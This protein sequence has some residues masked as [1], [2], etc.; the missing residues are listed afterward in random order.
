M[1]S[2]KVAMV[3]AILLM[4][5]VVA[6]QAQEGKV[7]GNCMSECYFQCMQIRIFTWSECRSKCVKACTKPSRGVLKDGAQKKHTKE[8]IE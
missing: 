2:T 4:L 8:A 5:V 7:N 3:E 6:V 1:A